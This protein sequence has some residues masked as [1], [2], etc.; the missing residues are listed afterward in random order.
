MDGEQL[1]KRNFYE[2]KKGYTVNFPLTGG[3]GKP[4]IEGRKK[5]FM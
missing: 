2:I 5:I 4:V 1:L 3:G